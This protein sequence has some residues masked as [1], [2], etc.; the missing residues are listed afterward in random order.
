MLKLIPNVLGCRVITNSMQR[1]GEEVPQ[2]LPALAM[3]GEIQLAV[4]LAVRSTV[5]EGT[6]GP[7][8]CD[9]A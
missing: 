9:C 1:S 2:Q 7:Q 4:G 8:D 6:E 3:F 5:K